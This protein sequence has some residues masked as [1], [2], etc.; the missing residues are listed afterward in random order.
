MVSRTLFRQIIYLERIFQIILMI[1]SVHGN[2]R[3]RD[4]D[5]KQWSEI[6]L[7]QVAR[8]TYSSTPPVHSPVTSRGR[9]PSDPGSPSTRTSIDPVHLD[10]YRLPRAAVLDFQSTLS[11][12]GRTV[13]SSPKC[14]LECRHQ[15]DLSSLGPTVTVV[16]V[17][18]ALT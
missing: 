6:G 12:K 9:G 1:A 10:S 11:T 3:V 4:T 2:C 14:R 5:T 18:S 13:S 7:V 17:V 8:R 16:R 15:L